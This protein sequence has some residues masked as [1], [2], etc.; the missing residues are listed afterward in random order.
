[1]GT[2]RSISSDM[3]NFFKFSVGDRV[4]V[5]VDADNYEGRTGVVNLVDFDDLE[6]PF[7]VKIDGTENSWW[8]G[9]SELFPSVATFK[10]GDRVIVNDDRWHDEHGAYVR[11]EGAG[12]VPHRVRLDKDGC[13]HCFDMHELTAVTCTAASDECDQ[14]EPE[15][16]DYKIVIGD[17]Y[18]PASSANTYAEAFEMAED[19]AKQYDMDVR[20]YKLVAEI[21]PVTTMVRKTF[22]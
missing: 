2:Q 17:S 1:M 7:M 19:L 9:A 6:L 5:G 22:A 13:E 11:D 12:I 20:V 21:E 14:D 10:A 4:R 18:E 3:T 16:P 15:S 8:Y